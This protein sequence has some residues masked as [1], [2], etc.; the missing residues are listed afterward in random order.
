MDYIL[1]LVAPPGSGR[2]TDGAVE[3]LRSRANMAGLAFGPPKWLCAGEACDLPLGSVDP[4]EIRIWAANALGDFSLDVAVTPR[5]GR[6]KKFLI[7][8]MDATIVVGETLDELAA[9]AGS[10]AAVAAITERAMRG[11]LDFKQALIERVAT[12][13]GLDAGVIDRVIEDIEIT[14]GAATLVATMAAH[15][16]ATMLVSGG[17]TPFVA[18]VADRLGFA[19][20]QANELEIVDAKLTGRVVPPILDR[21]AKVAALEKLAA[22]RDLA[23]QDGLA[24]GDGANDLG[25]IEAAGLGAAWRGKPVLK[26]HADVTID[27]GDLTAL[28]YFQGYSIQMFS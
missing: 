14:P 25:M 4:D 16:A 28:L 19:S 1:T 2:L 8:D 18:H 26:K 13:E 5:R 15:G 12:L 22:D 3:V 23:A 7:A 17:F 10:G 24:V 21:E 6:R 20:M 11:E 27:H 9:R